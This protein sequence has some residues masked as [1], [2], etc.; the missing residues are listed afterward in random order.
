[1]WKTAKP[2]Y[3]VFTCKLPISSLQCHELLICDD[4]VGNLVQFGFCIFSSFPSTGVKIPIFLL[5]LL[6]IVIAAL[7]CSV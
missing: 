3:D 4:E 7:S 5:T 6:L 2:A 1:M